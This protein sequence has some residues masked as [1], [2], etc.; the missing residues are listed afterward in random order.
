MSGKKSFDYSAPE[1]MSGDAAWGYIEAVLTSRLASVEDEIRHYPSPIPACDAQF[2]YLLAQRS[3]LRRELAKVRAA[4][5]TSAPKPAQQQ[6][7]DE[8]V[9]SCPC[10]HTF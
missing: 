4:L 5:N 7:L 3:N 8:F 6:M 2:N 1:M 9:S 10:V